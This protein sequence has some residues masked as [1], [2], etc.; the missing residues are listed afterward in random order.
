MANLNQD[1]LAK[2]LAMEQ[3]EQAQN[4]KSKNAQPAD[5]YAK[6]KPTN[7]P[8]IDLNESVAEY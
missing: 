7:A 3:A 6:S 4:Q 5:P 1:A 2:F 8:A